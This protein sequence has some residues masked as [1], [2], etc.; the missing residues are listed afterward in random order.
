MWPED[1]F[2]GAENLRYRDRSGRSCQ[3]TPSGGQRRMPSPAGRSGGS[4]AGTGR[5]RP[6]PARTAVACPVGGAGPA[7]P[8][9]LDERVAVLHPG[10][11][12]VPALGI[13]LGD[14]LREGCP[15]ARVIRHQ[16]TGN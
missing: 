5:G 13:T 7:R 2:G 16:D 8:R 11:G 14:S 3:R 6:G 10:Q 9:H 12:A 1:G 4:R 15:G